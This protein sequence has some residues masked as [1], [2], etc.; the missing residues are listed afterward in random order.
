MDKGLWHHPQLPWH[1]RGPATSPPTPPNSS[2]VLPEQGERSGRGAPLGAP[3]GRAGGGAASICSF[4]SRLGHRVPLPGEQPQAPVWAARVGTP[5]QDPRPWDPP[6][7][8]PE[9]RT[10]HRNRSRLRSRDAQGRQEGLTPAPHKS[11]ASSKPGLLDTKSRVGGE[12]LITHHTA[13]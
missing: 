8:Q 4:R 11:L 1:V 7:Q 2:H 5:A 6:P 10:R 13:L 3:W 9:N 12:A